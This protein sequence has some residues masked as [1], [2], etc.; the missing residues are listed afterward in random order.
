MKIYRHCQ[1]PLN[2][3]RRK[4]EE[5]WK[6]HRHSINW[7]A[8]VPLSSREKTRTM[9]VWRDPSSRRKRKRRIATT[10]D[11]ICRS[12]FREKKELSRKPPSNQCAIADPKPFRQRFSPNSASSH[13]GR[14]TLS[15]SFPAQ[16]TYGPPTAYA[17]HRSGRRKTCNRRLSVVR[18]WCNL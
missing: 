10:D 3:P 9:R 2:A 6:C 7:L 8:S 17:F 5:I 18:C 14:V 15:D 12:R 11:G 13:S 4:K 1:T 16:C